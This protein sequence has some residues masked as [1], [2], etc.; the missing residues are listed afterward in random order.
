MTSLR[1]DAEWFMETA[2]L[3]QYNPSDFKPMRFELEP[4]SAVLA[5]PAA[6]VQTHLW[7]LDPAA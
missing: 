6:A 2:D 1:S 5:A 7:L 3:F 4:K